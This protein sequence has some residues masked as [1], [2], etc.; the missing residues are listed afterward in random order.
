MKKAFSLTVV[1]A[2]LFGFVTTILAQTILYQED[3]G[4]TNSGSAIAY[5]YNASSPAYPFGQLGWS[6]VM[7]AP[8]A[9]TG[10]PYEGIYVATGANDSTTGYSLPANTVYY[11]GITAGQNG[12]LYTVAGAGNGGSGDSAFPAGGINPAG[13]VTL[14]AEVTTEGSA[15]VNYFAVQVGGQWYMSATPMAA[16]APPYPQFVDVCLTYTTTASAWNTLT[17]RANTVTIGSTAPSNLS[18]NITGIGIVQ[19]GPGGWNYNEIA[20]QSSCGN[21][22]VGSPAAIQVAPFSQSTYAG[23]GV[24]FVVQASGS[25]PLTYTWKQNGVA[26]TNGGRISGATTGQL[27]I[28]NVNSA[29]GSAT[30][31]VDVSNDNGKSTATATGFTLTVNPLPSD[32][33]YAETV[34]YIGTREIFPY[35]ALDGSRRP[36]MAA[37]TAKAA[38]RVLYSPILA[39]PIQLFILLTVILTL[40]KRVWPFRP[41]IQLVIHILHFRLPWMPIAA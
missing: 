2:A 11:T 26:L 5:A 17:V 31:E 25:A 35:P 13:G 40:T 20:I 14:N 38:A 23:G 19:V 32:Y 7:P 39:Q 18:G 8:Q 1:L 36:Q 9:G 3:W 37:S 33:L 24:T 10:P 12:F 27:T 4:T 16:S 22:G 29:D 6:I 15:A 30:Y 34:P 28:T 41:S 21:L